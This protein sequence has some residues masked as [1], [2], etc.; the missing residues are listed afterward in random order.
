[1]FVHV[2]KCAGQSIEVFFLQRVGLDW[3]RRAPFLL[4]PNDTA[5]LGPPRLAHSKAHQYVENK[6]MTPAQFDEYFKFTFVRNPWD[7]LVSFY[8][9]LGFDR[10]CSFSRFVQKHLPREYEK[11]SWF[12]CP[13]V[14]YIYRPDGRLLVDFVGRF[15]ALAQDFAA[16]CERMGIADTQLPHINHSRKSASGLMRWFRRRHLSYREMYDTRSRQLVAKLYEADVDA[17]KYQF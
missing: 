14:E 13:Q 7:R 10:R 1:L 17:F 3:E 16:V 2:P 11:K 12:M 9:Y 8:R 6:W 5:E 15:E 4:R